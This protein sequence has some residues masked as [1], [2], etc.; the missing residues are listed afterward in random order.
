M[1][2]PT[3]WPAGLRLRAALWALLTACLCVFSGL[4]Q[5]QLIDEIELQREGR[6]AVMHIRFATPVQLLHA[7]SGSS[8]DNT[9]I[10]YRVLPTPQTLELGPAERR[11]PPNAMGTQLPGITVTDL[12]SSDRGSD[13]R[14][15]RMSLSKGVSHTVRTGRDPRTIDV[16]LVGLG[17]QLPAQ[18]EA[19]LPAAVAGLLRVTLEASE[20]PGVL[21]AAIPA[22][23]QEVNVFTSRRVINGRVVYETHVGPFATRAEAESALRAVRSRFPQAAITQD[24]ASV[25]VAVAAP[26]PAP[27]TAPPLS[28]PAPA[29]AAS[30]P[31]AAP[32]P[33][34]VTPPLTDAQLDRQAQGL[35]RAAQASLAAGATQDAVD[36]LGKLLDLPPNGASRQAQ[37]LIGQARLKLGDNA[38]ARAEYEAFLRLYPTGADSDRARTELA[39]LAGSATPV[40]A[41][42]D[43]ARDRAARTSTL[44][45]SVS[46]YYY[47]GQSKV[48]TQE[49]QDSPI[50]GLPQ[51]VSE[52]TL[53]DTDQSLLVTATDVNWRQRDAD[54][55]QR[56][57]F[58]D[59]YSKD[60]NR[61][62]KSRNRLSALYYDHKSFAL[63]TQVRLGR[64]SPLGGGVL[65]RFD[66]VQAGYT[67]KPRWK[68]HA[69]AG[70]PAD[71]LL[72][73]RRF[74]YGASVDAEALTPHLGG[75]L[76]AIEQKVDGLV[77]RRA[78]GTELRYF[79]GGLS[80]SGQ[81]DQD[82]LLKGLNIASVQGTWQ[83][84]GGTVFNM[85]LDRRKTPLLM[86]G[87]ALFFGG[88]AATRMSD[89]LAA[90]ATPDS[91]RQQV[92]DTTANATQ[93]SLGVTTPLST[94]W[95]LGVDVR[96]TNIGAIAPVADLLPQG[97]PSSGD[98]WSAGLQFIG[99]N[100]YSARDT[101]VLIANFINGP[102]F[103]GQLLSYNNSSV[104]VP[105]LQLEP[106]FKYYRQ[107]TSDQM[108]STRWSPGL[109]LTWRPQPA[110]ALESELSLESSKT[111]SALRHES[112]TRTYY[113]L[114]GRYDF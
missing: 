11:L 9:L 54:A 101:H 94:R 108:V 50:G 75:S 2:T 21:S 112:S 82:I 80:L 28:A 23:L 44:N 3:P 88:G 83:R 91:L 59:S 61:P 36:A 78:L 103:Q 30:A 48:R 69:V 12:P 19:E 46:S 113:Y 67:F 65:G 114:G 97:Q 4:A 6:D 72:D 40:A 1:N 37:L 45:G 81:L 70:Q 20:Q 33:A 86:L 96:Y 14:R 76:Y 5:A 104:L 26:A 93:A 90:G 17:R 105:G 32:A 60:F 35:L 58:R 24:E 51:L 53:S 8:A 42:G 43:K 15:L 10:I 100:L 22:A 27:A 18:Q 98:I 13:E 31:E 84:E 16:V 49:F 62:E 68:V 66:G 55:D 71:K 85:M 39:A 29:P 52:S 92:R 38:R 89:L 107:S 41:A 57:V 110:V 7:L 34:V 25:A 79:D 74:F 106:S 95:Q 87:N 99:S 77:D 64:Q 109:R 63:G 56:F 102:T 111:T 47:G 73:T